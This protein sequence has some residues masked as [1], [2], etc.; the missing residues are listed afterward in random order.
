MSDA[1]VTFFV[2]AAVIIG[3]MS[4]V[5]AILLREILTELEK[6]RKP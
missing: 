1:A 5:G 3:V 2:C 4:V 6:Q